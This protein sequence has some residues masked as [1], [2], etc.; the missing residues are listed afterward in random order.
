MKKIEAGLGEK[1]GFSFQHI[2]SFIT[3]FVI[4]FIYGWKLT[5]VIL[6]AVPVLMVA[7][8]IMAYVSSHWEY[9][10]I[11]CTISCNLLSTVVRRHV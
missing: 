8:G 9:C 1:V 3:G 10:A 4:G 2:S 5:L 6:A 7:G 11:Y